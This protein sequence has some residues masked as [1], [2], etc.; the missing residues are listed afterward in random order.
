MAVISHCCRLFICK[1]ASSA[2][3]Q[4]GFIMPSANSRFKVPVFGFQVSDA[5][6]EVPFR[7]LPRVEEGGIGPVAAYELAPSTDGE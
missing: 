6:V 5:T 1:A 4:A 7:I 2:W 3:A